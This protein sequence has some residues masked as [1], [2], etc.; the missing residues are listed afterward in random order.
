V[1]FRKIDKIPFFQQAQETRG[2]IDVMIENIVIVKNIQNNVL[3]HTNRG[4]L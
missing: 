4:V 2:L 3:L 1:C